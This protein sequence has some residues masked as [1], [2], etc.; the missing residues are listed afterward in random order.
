MTASITKLSMA[1][2]LRCSSCGAPGSGSCSCGAGYIPAGEHAAKLAREHPELSSR[3]LAAQTGV[4]QRTAA[5]ALHSVREPYGSGESVV[6]GRDGKT[7]PARTS[8]QRKLLR[9]AGGNDL[10]AAKSHIRQSLSAFRQDLTKE[11]W[12]TLVAWLKEEKWETHH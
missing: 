8:T 3:D 2:A 10:N 9:I 1:V 11:E 4:S 5:R 7:Y 6:I 12:A